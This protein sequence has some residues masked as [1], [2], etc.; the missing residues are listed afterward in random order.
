MQLEL[1]VYVTHLHQ[2]KATRICVL[3]RRFS[4][5]PKTAIY[6][7]SK[8]KIG[9]AVDDKRHKSKGQP[10]KSILEDNDIIDQSTELL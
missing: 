4:E 1:K 2:D 10:G 9:R 5:Y 8:R 3:E 6:G 7:A